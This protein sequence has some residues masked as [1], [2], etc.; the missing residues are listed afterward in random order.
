MENANNVGVKSVNDYTLEV[1]LNRR[2]NYFDQFM[3]FCVFFPQNQ[4]FV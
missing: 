3:S 2:I 4:K 1:K